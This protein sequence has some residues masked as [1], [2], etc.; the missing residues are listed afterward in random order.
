MTLIL[1]ADDD[2]DILELVTYKLENSG[3]KV[4]PVP[5]G[6]EAIRCAR[7]SQPDLMILDVMMP[8]HSGI[9]VTIEIRNDSTL[10]N[11]PIILLTARSM[12]LDTERG[13]AAGATDYMT[14]PFSPRELLSRVEAV[15]GRN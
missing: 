8:F 2:P 7:E 5:D 9:E 11:V 14:K 12:E 1:V 6:A 15:L 3:Y 4:I 10:K 13:F